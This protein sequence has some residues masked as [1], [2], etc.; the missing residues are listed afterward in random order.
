VGVL[1][2]LAMALLIV[3]LTGLI[4]RLGYRLKA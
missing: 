2:S 4:A 3:G 1:G